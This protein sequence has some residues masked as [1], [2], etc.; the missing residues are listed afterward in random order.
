MPKRLETLGGTN[1]FLPDEADLWRV[2]E[3]KAV[4]LL[5]RYGFREI[6]TP[7][8]ESAE[9]FSRSLGT[10]SEVVQK[11]MYL[12]KD[13]GG[14]E[15]VLRPEGTAP[16]VRAYLEHGL[17]KTQSLVKW[18][19]L[20][21]MFRAERPQAGRR[22]QF[23]Q[24]G[25]EVFGSSSPEQDAEVMTLHLHLL[26]ALGVKKGVL[27]INQ[28][29]C[30]KDRPWILKALKEFFAKH[31]SDLCKDCVA[32]LDAN[33]LRVLD[34]KQEG[35]HR[36]I[37]SGKVPEFK[38]CGD[39]KVHGAK[40]VAALKLLKTPFEEDRFLV[41]GLDYYTRTAFE[42]VHSDLGAQNALG[43]GGRYD[44]LVEQMGGSAVPAV[45]FAMGL[46]RVL[47]ALKAEGA[48]ME[49]DLPDSVLVATLGAAAREAG[50]GLTHKLRRAGL[51]VTGDFEDRAI[52]RKLETANKLG[53]A[54]VV[55]LGDD[56]L[57]RTK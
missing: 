14:R 32:R 46:E 48:K 51:A 1:D 27:K 30:P 16:V 42:V 11:Q 37:T 7:V 25:V 13:R 19:Y 35:C 40:V 3:A 12:F 47:M 18:Y 15:V 8:M 56:E 54:V 41:R 50:F 39:C 20:G 34:C 26:E 52:K 17:D 22:R 10:G 31:K 33:P 2:C 38:L 49:S 6:R 23:H 24:L 28:L 9:V 4:Q 5:H 53:S 36:L 45:G 44:E 21:P 43:G 57:S 55:L 29:G